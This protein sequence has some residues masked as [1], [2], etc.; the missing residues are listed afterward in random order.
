[1]EK[2]LRPIALTFLYVFSFLLSFVLGALLVYV[3]KG[4]SIELDPDS[5]LFGGISVVL[6]S[7][8]NVQM[9]LMSGAISVFFG[10]SMNMADFKKAYDFRNVDWKNAWKAVVGIIFFSLFVNSFFS[11]FDTGV[12]TDLSDVLAALG[13]TK[14]GFVALIVL[15]PVFIELVFRESILRWMLNNGASKIRALLFASLCYSMMSI[16]TPLSMPRHFLLALLPGIVYLKRC[17]VVL[18]TISQ[19]FMYSIAIIASVLLEEELHNEPTTRLGQ[20]ELFCLLA[21]FAYPCYRIMRSYYTDEPV[22]PPALW[23][24]VKRVIVRAKLS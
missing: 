11:I 10:W 4:D 19:I 9:Q 2:Y 22:M 3:F 24:K 16:N 13:H 21:I 5:G 23:F 8:Y 17:N 18:A 14:V 7:D 12:D 6:L 20:F 15:M 1:M